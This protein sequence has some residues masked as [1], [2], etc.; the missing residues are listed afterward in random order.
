MKKKARRETWYKV[1]SADDESCSGGHHTTWSLPTA[2]GPGDWQVLPDEQPVVWCYSGFH[3]TNAPHLW[4]STGRRVYVA[5][6]RGRAARG[7]KT[8]RD[9]K[10]ACREVRLLRRVVGQELER[11]VRAKKC[12]YEPGMGPLAS[13]ATQGRARLPR[14]AATSAGRLMVEHVMANTPATSRAERGRVRASAIH[15]AV[16]AGLPFAKIDFSGLGTRTESDYAHAV[17]SRN[18]SACRSFEYAQGR[19]PFVYGGWR[20][21]VGSRLRWDGEDARVTSFTSDGRAVV[22]CTYARTPAAPD[23]AGRSAYRPLKVARR[24][25]IP[26]AALAAAEK[27]RLA[28]GK[29]AR[30]GA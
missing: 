13:R 6:Y 9:D 18:V 1:L 24:I 27:A 10:I 26:R 25:T 2:K 8:T 20:I 3:L 21:A 30:R 19:G 12:P 14:A 23:D 17:A 15:L 22:V 4:W 28:A 11:L 29:K 5:E 16:A 7:P